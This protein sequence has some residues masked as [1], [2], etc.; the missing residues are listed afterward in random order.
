MRVGW[1]DIYMITALVLAIR[2][3]S[4]CINCSENGPCC[5]SFGCSL[6]PL[7]IQSRDASNLPMEDDYWSIDAIF[8]ESQVSAGMFS[9]L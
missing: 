7:D 9:V 3:T 5:P 2:C 6:L 8:N 4:S 1:L